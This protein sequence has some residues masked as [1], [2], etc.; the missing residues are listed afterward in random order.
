[1]KKISFLLLLLLSVAQLS[2]QSR[3][4]K[5]IAEINNPKSNYVLVALHRGD[6]RHFPENSIEGIES[7]IKMGGDIIELDLA[8]TADSVLVLSHDRTI[9]RATTGKGRIEELSYDSLKRVFLRD[10][11]GNPTKYKMPTL[12][13]ALK[14][15]KG[16]IVVNVDKGYQYFD[17]LQAL[18]KEM[19]VEN[20]ILLKGKSSVADVASRYAGSQSQMMYMPIIDI[21]KP[22]GKKLFDEYMT[23]K[24]VPLAYE[25][26]WNKLTP[27]V[28][29]CFRTIINSGSK[30]WVNTL[31]DSLNG[32]LT[33]D[34]AFEGN[35]DEVYGKLLDMGATMIQS[36]RPEFLLNYLRS[37]GLHD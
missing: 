10:E 18:A 29:D 32:G 17:L 13:D 1:M 22:A 25:V 15:C 36:D 28:T 35:P 37:K 11:E 7:S 12:R 33:D 8:L 26:C 5:I 9:D 24:T 23:T 19:G 16:K 14:T 6:W 34:K 21:L 2:A 27:E 30:L 3:V 31:W 20:Q 4:D